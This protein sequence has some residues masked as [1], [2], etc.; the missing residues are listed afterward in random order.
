MPSTTSFRFGDIVHVPF[1]F[2]DQ[3]LSPAPPSAAPERLSGPE[4]AQA[5][6]A[7]RQG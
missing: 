7:P 5:A 6:H 2:T 1:P 3:T 4:L